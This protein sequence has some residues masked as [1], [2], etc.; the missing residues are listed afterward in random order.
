MNGDESFD[1]IIAGG[2]FVGLTLARAMSF[3]AKGRMRICVIDRVPLSTMVKAEPNGRAF[4]ISAS[5]RRM[6][7]VLDVWRH[8]G[9]A[10][11]PVTAFDITDSPLHSPLRPVLLQIDSEVA[12]GEPSAHIVENHD[13]L[14]A[15]AATVHGDKAISVLAPDKVLGFIRNDYSISVQRANGSS[16]GASLLVAADGRK[17]SLRDFAQIKTVKWAYPQV[18]IVTTVGHEKP[19]HGRAVQHFLPAG[20]FAILPLKGNRSSLVW[21]ETSETGRTIM[22]SDDDAFLDALRERFGSRLGSLSI[23]GPRFAYP[24]DFHLARQFTADRFALVGDA[25]H[26]VHPIAGLGF[27]IGLRDVAALTEVVIDA[28][29]L[30]LD[31]GSETILKRYQRWRRFDSAFSALVMDGLNRLFSSDNAPIRTVRDLGIGLVD[32]APLLKR[33]FVQE[34]AG[35]SGDVPRLLKG[36]TL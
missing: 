17:S 24:L 27:N 20:P 16:V 4:A 30:G 36:E 18:G 11:Q 2:G 3:A 32:R 29:R 28:S 19:H 10:A 35:F 22:E 5:S 25:A 12:P 21:T 6:L 34:A 9:D 13:L 31:I 14:R 33:F 26:G 15:L 7:E 8:V 1:L 23:A